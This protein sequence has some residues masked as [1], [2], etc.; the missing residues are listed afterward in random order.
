M[1]LLQCVVLCNVLCCAVCYNTTYQAFIAAPLV[2]S[3]RFFGYQTSAS[4]LVGGVAK[5]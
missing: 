1:L 5:G 4:S 2:I 3:V